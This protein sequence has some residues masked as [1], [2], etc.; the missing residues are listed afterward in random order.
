MIETGTRTRQNQA[1]TTEFSN[2]MTRGFTRDVGMSK[3]VSASLT[4]GSGQATAA[5]G[6]G[7]FA[8]ND[9]VLVENT[10]LN[11]GFFTVTSVAAGALGL[12]PPPKA[13]GPI[14]AT[15]RTV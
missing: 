14:S 15:I 4:F 12:Q 3:N 2:G 5:S 8:V 1:L 6:L 11:N 13:E 10:N 9:L 7:V